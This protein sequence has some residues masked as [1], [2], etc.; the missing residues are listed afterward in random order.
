MVGKKGKNIPKGMG[1]AGAAWVV[2]QQVPEPQPGGFGGLFG[3]DFGSARVPAA[4]GAERGPE[5]P[6]EHPPFCSS[7][8]ARGN[9]AALHCQPCSSPSSELCLVPPAHPRGAHPGQ[10]YRNYI[11]VIPNVA[12]AAFLMCLIHEGLHGGCRAVL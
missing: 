11:S 4:P 3:K 5:V 7:G 10:K 2:H 9:A 1:R 8:A 6:P 12:A